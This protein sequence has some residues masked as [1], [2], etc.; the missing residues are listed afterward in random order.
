MSTRVLIADDSPAVRAGLTGILA[1]TEFEVA[2]QAATCDQALQ[3]TLTCVPDLVLLDL[4]MPDGD[5]FC[6]A[7]KIKAEH[8]ETRVLC[9]TAAE[10]SP[11]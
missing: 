3:Y 1:G 11:R 8:P 6:V 4:R 2:A 5:S 7:E 9:F 10:T